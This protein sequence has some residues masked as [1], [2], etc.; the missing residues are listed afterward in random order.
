MAIALPLELAER[1]L[2]WMRG[3]SDYAGMRLEDLLSEEDLI[4][5]VV[6]LQNSCTVDK[7]P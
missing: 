7:S 4:A 1:I 6:A 5:C 3:D 2:S